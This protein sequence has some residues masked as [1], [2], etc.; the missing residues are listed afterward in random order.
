MQMVH[1]ENIGARKA[2]YV[3]IPKELS[4]NTKSALQSIGINKLYSHQVWMLSS[5]SI[6]LKSID[7]ACV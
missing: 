2:S 5:T 1:V 3:E 4:D 6:F 7:L